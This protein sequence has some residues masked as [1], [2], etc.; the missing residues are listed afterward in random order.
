MIGDKGMIIHMLLYLSQILNEISLAD[1]VLILHWLL[2][3]LY[4]SGGI[5]LKDVYANDVIVMMV[6]RLNHFRG[7]L[8]R[9]KSKFNLFTL[10]Q[11]PSSSF[12][13]IWVKPRKNGHFL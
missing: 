6:N 1:N 12:P 9:A 13:Q 3:L 7:H 4:K 5:F 2:T 8:F 10:P 11:L